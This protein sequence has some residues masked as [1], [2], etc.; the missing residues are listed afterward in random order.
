MGLNQET[1]TSNAVYVG[2]SEG[3]CRV[4]FREPN[5]STTERVN[6]DGVTVYEYVADSL[7][8]IVTAVN[9]VTTDFG[10]QWKIILQDDQTYVLSL[11]HDGAYATTIVQAL[12]NPAFDPSKPVKIIPYSFTDKERPNRTITGC[13]VQ[14]DGKKLE[15][16]YCSSRNPVAGKVELPDWVAVIVNGQTMYD[17]TA[18]LEFIK[19]EVATKLTPRLG[20]AKVAV[21]TAPQAAP[22]V[23]EEDDGSLPF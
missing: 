6:K 21:P 4:K 8:G 12:C 23:D 14:Q 11:K 3:K 22:I 10:P 9:H 7:S 15:R 20:S 19:S 2:I 13:Q 1:P 16:L 5:A 18:Q 17:K